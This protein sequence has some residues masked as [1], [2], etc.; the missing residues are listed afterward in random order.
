MC[1]FGHRHT[2]RA[3]FLQSFSNVR[4]FAKAM[5]S[6]VEWPAAPQLQA[7]LVREQCAKIV[8]DLQV[9]VCVCACARTRVCE[10]GGEEAG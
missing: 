9:C 8:R 7:L 1:E 2:V 6:S 4:R 3:G 10:C 5:D